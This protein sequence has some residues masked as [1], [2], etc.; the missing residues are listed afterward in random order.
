MNIFE[1]KIWRRL[2]TFP[3][4]YYL[5]STKEKYTGNKIIE[6]ILLGLLGDFNLPGINWETL[7]GSRL[8]ENRFLDLL[9]DIDLFQSITEPTHIEGNTFDLIATSCPDI[10]YPLLC[11]SLLHH[12][13]I[14]IYLPEN[15]IDHDVVSLQQ[16]SKSSFDITA[17]NFALNDFYM[18]LN[19][20]R[21]C[22]Y[23]FM[24]NWCHE[25]AKALALGLTPKRTKRNNYP[26]FYSSHTLHL[27]NK[28]DT[29]LSK[30]KKT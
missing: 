22:Y 28:R 11:K 15:T 8:Y 2:G 19:E 7:S 17:F 25:M 14:A 29:L 6:T 12:Y 3:S 27:I 23:G 9:Y 4:C 30:I 21:I 26:N 5:S 18:L 13:P 16:Y 20:N 1:P 10:T 24:Q